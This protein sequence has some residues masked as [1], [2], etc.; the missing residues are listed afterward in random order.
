[1]KVYEVEGKIRS[2]WNSEVRAIIDTWTTYM[3][4]L[5]EFK[6]S[7]LDNSLLF[8][9]ANN[10]QAWIV[11]SSQAKGLFSKEQLAFI[12]KAVFPAFHKAGIKYF[13]TIKPTNS[14]FTEMT[15]KQYSAL[16]GPHGVQLVEVSNVDQAIMWLKS[17]AK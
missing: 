4:S 15:V 1:M 9:K 2:E 5:E 7:V 11:D 8:A 6:T 16:S 12:D 3:I 14:V 17:N 10:G 13:I